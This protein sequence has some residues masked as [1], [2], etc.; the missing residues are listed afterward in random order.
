MLM[1]IMMYWPCYTDRCVFCQK[2]LNSLF[3]QLSN[4]FPQSNSYPLPQLSTQAG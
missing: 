2:P 3:V 1:C 4:P